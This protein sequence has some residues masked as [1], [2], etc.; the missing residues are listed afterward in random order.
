VPEDACRTAHE[1]F[2]RLDQRVA[3]LDQT[4]G[5]AIDEVRTHRLVIEDDDGLEWIVG[6]VCGGE[7]RLRLQIP[8]RNE[9]GGPCIVVFACGASY[10]LDPTVGVQLWAD[11]RAIAGIEMWPSDDGRWES[12]GAVSSTR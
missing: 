2:V 3:S 10:G 11:E 6:E 5:Q 9:S 7:A 4:R 8:S 12:H 1:L